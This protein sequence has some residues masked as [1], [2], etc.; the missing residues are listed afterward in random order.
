MHNDRSPTPSD[1]PKAASLFLFYTICIVH[2]WASFIYLTY[3][4]LILIPKRKDRLAALGVTLGITGLL[5]SLSF[6]L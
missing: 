3:L 2:P 4:M 5:L 1:P 6:T